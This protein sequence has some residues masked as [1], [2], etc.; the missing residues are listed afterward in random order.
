[1]FGKVLKWYL[2]LKMTCNV[3]QTLLNQEIKKLSQCGFHH[4]PESFE[5]FQLIQGK[6]AYEYYGS[7][8][9]TIQSRVPVLINKNRLEQSNISPLPPK[10]NGE[11]VLSRKSQT[12]VRCPQWNGEKTLKEDL[13]RALK[14]FWSSWRTLFKLLSVAPTWNGE[15]KINWYESSRIREYPMW[16]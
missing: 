10:W 16:W 7:L 8:N 6:K 14:K 4:F 3:L 12:Y 15:N 1:M 5:L 9:W 2:V 13:F 11:K